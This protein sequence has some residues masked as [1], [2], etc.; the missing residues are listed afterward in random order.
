MDGMKN[1]LGVSS[2]ISQCRLYSPGLI[3]LQVNKNLILQTSGA[4]SFFG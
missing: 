4:E 3:V 1:F 2:Q